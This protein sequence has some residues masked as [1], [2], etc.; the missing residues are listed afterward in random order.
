V[1]SNGTETIN[2]VFGESRSLPI[3]YLIEHMIDYQQRQKYHDL[4]LNSCEWSEEGRHITPY[5]RDIQVRLA[6]TASR[7]NVQFVDQN[8]PIYRARVQS[9]TVTS[10]VGYIE[11]TVNLDTHEAECPC[12]Y[13]DEMGISCSHIKAVL[14]ALNRQSTWCNRRYTMETY[15]D[16]YSAPIPS[17]VVASKVE[18]DKTF[19]PPNFKRPAGRPSKKKKSRSQYRGIAQR[20]CRACGRLGHY[21]MKCPEPSTEYRYYQHKDSAIKWCKSV[22]AKMIPEN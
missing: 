18:V 8:H 22:E 10:L 12:F 19:L 7:K 20:E 3:V 5:A 6:D 15:K 21:A 17:M 11:V 2:G 13:Y 14:L 16:S 4:Y 9:T 1:T